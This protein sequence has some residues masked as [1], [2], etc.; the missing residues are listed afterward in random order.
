M[1]IL[2]QAFLLRLFNMH[3]YD[4]ISEIFLS[5]CVAYI[6]YDLRPTTI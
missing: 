6:K 2:G 1:G 4:F 5:S 3:G